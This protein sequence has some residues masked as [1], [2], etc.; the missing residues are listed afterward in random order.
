VPYFR[1]ISNLIAGCD[2]M[3]LH[4]YLKIRPHHQLILI[5]LLAYTVFLLCAYF[6]FSSVLTP[7]Y[8]IFDDLHHEVRAQELSH[9]SLWKLFFSSETGIPVFFGVLILF[10]KFFEGEVLITNLKALNLV[11]HFLNA[12]F[13]YQI[14]VVLHE[15]LNLTSKSSPQA[16]RISS[17]LLTCLFVIHPLQVE[18]LAWISSMKGTLACTFVL[19]AVWLKLSSYKGRLLSRIIIHLLILIFYTLSLWSKPSLIA[20]PV[21]FFL[22]DW[23]LLG[24]SLKTSILNNSFLLIAAIP[25]G[26]FHIWTFTP[27]IFSLVVNRITNPFPHL[28]WG[29]LIP[30]ISLIAA[31][32]I[33]ILIYKK[34]NRK[35]DFFLY[36]SVITALILVIAYWPFFVTL[37]A[38]TNGSIVVFSYTLFKIIYP[39]QL[40]FDHGLNLDFLMLHYGVIKQVLAVIFASAL[41][42]YF[43]SKRIT[44]SIIILY[45]LALPYLGFFMYEFG[46]I[47]F[48]ADRFAYPI[49]A[50]LCILL[51]YPLSKVFL[52]YPLATFAFIFALSAFSVQKSNKQIEHWASSE[53]FLKHSLEINPT[54][55]AT[56]LAMASLYELNELPE[57]SIFYYNEAVALSAHNSETYLSLLYLLLRMQRYD[58]V[59]KT[60]E[61]IGVLTPVVDRE[62]FPILAR[63]YANIGDLDRA[64]FFTRI[65]LM[66][67]PWHE[68]SQN[69]IEFIEQMRLIMNDDNEK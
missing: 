16:I 50:A 41:L 3:I 47:S 60:V 21:I 5:D 14:S 38:K 67:M 62:V 30:I 20:L 58:D 2:R 55:V 35:K 64:E 10:S 33:S 66:H 46:Y 39:A 49:L 22:L 26:Y 23:R 61:N 63:T 13:V 53:A 48:F 29:W 15:K 59:L 32:C 24:Q 25:V 7:Q 17:L 34:I 51:T 42:I 4:N 43:R 37:L 52:R 40:G 68:F 44:L 69:M 1:K 36:G 65:T 56:R 9:L 45:L 27:W 28:Q 31:S 57:V 54:S 19:I 6:V 18:S 12:V 11:L 8:F